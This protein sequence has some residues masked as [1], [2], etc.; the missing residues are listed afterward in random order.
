MLVHSFGR[1]CAVYQCQCYLTEVQA[2]DPAGIR[3]YVEKHPEHANWEVVCDI[4]RSQ[5]HLPW[6]ENVLQFMAACCKWNEQIFG[7]TNA[8]K[9]K[10]LSRLNGITRTEPRFGLNSK[11]EELQRSLWQEMEAVLIQESLIWAQKS[12]SEWMVDG[13][14]NTRYF[15]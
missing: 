2:Y 10:L 8:R 4:L 3:A 9:R 14:R 12:R 15:H 6:T 1:V 7:Y 11:L 13:Y 5:A